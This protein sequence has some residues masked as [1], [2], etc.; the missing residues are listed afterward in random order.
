MHSKRTLENIAGL[1]RKFRARVEVFL[2]LLEPVKAKH[3]I[4]IEVISGFR[5]GVQQ[6]AL[7]AQG[8]TRPGKIVTKARP[9]LSWH[10]YGLAIDLGLFRGGKYLD[11]SNPILATTIYREIAAIAEAEE[12][13]WAGRWKNFPETPHF[14]WRNGMSLAFAKE[15]MAKVNYDVQRLI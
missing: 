13:E 14:Q 8:R 11:A 7:F 2:A 15:K 1:N 6:A 4:T 3:G 10:N 9:W 12:L 5:S